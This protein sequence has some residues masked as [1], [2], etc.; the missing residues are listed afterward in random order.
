MTYRRII[1]V[2]RNPRFIAWRYAK[3]HVLCRGQPRLGPFLG[4]LL[5]REP[6]MSRPRP[7]C[8]SSC[9]DGRNKSGH[10][11]VSPLVKFE[12]SN[13]AGELDD[14]VVAIRHLHLG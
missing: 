12:S 5:A 13:P 6:E 8:T 1:I 9:R 10:D 14:E 7:D 2:L 11:V 3:P 4:F